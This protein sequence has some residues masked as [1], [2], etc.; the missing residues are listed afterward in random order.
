MK[1]YLVVL[2]DGTE[3]VGWRGW[4]ERLWLD[5]WNS[6]YY[7]VVSIRRPDGSLTTFQEAGGVEVRK[8]NVLYYVGLGKE[9]KK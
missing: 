1:K 6:R 7:K 5:N 2:V 3:I 9:V 4:Y 8:S